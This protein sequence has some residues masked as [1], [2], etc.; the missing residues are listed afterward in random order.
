[1]KRCPYYAEDVQDAARRVQATLGGEKL[2]IP[3]CSELLV[4][5]VYRW[6]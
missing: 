4:W 3:S 1:M 2:G 5:R 6:V